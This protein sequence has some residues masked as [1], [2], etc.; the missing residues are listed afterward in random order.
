[1]LDSTSP[2]RIPKVSIGMPV[3]NGENY[4]K[5]ALD[6][7]LAQ[8]FTDFELII[9][10]NH[11]TD[12]TSEICKKFASADSRVRYIRQDA[13]IGPSANFQFVLQQA[14][15]HLFMWAAHDDIWSKNWLE[16]LVAN[17]QPDDL[18]IR[19]LAMTIDENNNL[20]RTTSVST[21]AKGQVIKAFLD[22]ESNSKAFYWY[23]LFDRG[24]LTKANLGLLND[25]VYGAD[26]ALILHLV[27]YGNLRSITSTQQYYR[28]H[29]SSVSGKLT[30]G[31]LNL[32]K[33]AYHFF[34]FSYYAYN[35]KV[36]SCRYKPLLLLSMPIKYFQSQAWLINKL[37]KKIL[38]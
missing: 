10:D 20:L 14:T 24:L 30:S 5:E 25:T 27:Q 6:S 34:P 21:F 35:Y 29:S 26:S 18:G 8:T 33:L 3:Y 4:I 15:G 38:K 28:E 11:S 1:M 16:E 12:G 22:K 13:N 23:A 36:I 32:E 19:G 7:L 9:S 37:F 31:W 17:I 2:K